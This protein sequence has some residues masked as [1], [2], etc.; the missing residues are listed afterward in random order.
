MNSNFNHNND[1]DPEIR[2]E[3]KYNEEEYEQEDQNYCDYQNKQSGN[4]IQNDGSN[5]ENNNT[6]SN[7]IDPIYVMSLE[8]GDKIE[9]IKIYPDSNPLDLA[10]NFCIKNNLDMSAV[11]YLKQQIEQ[12]II[13]YNNDEEEG[14]ENEEK[15]MV[16]NDDEN[17]DEILEEFDMGNNIENNMEKNM[18]NIKINENKNSNEKNNDGDNKNRKEIIS[19]IEKEENNGLKSNTIERDDNKIEMCDENNIENKKN[20]N[21]ESA[22][23]NN[24]KVRSSEKKKE[25]DE[26]NND[27][28]IY[29]NNQNDNIINNVLEK[30]VIYNKDLNNINLNKKNLNNNTPNQNEYSE[31]ELGNT[32]SDKRVSQKE[33]I[34][35]NSKKEPNIIEKPSFNDEK[36]LN[37]FINGKN[38]ESDIKTV[39]LQNKIKEK[40]NN[41]LN[42]NNLN[43]LNYFNN[44]TDLLDSDDGKEPNINE[45]N[46]TAEIKDVEGI[47]NN[48]ANYENQKPKYN[49]NNFNEN[50]I[51]IDK[52]FEKNNQRHNYPIFFNT[53]GKNENLNI[54]KDNLNNH[55]RHFMQSLE[56]NK[57]KIKGKK[58]N[59]NFNQVNIQS[60]NKKIS[61]KILLQ[62]N[63]KTP[64]L[65]Q[66]NI[67]LENK[68]KKINNISNRS[69]QYNKHNINENISEKLFKEAA[70][71][72]II[73]KKPCHFRENDMRFIKNLTYNNINNN[74]LYTN[75]ENKRKLSIKKLNLKLGNKISN[76]Y[77]EYLY[78]K[79][80]YYKEQKEKELSLLKQQKNDFEKKICTFKPN[81]GNNINQK[82]G[83]DKKCHSFIQN[84][85]ISN[86]SRKNL[87]TENNKKLGNKISSKINKNNN[88]FICKTMSFSNNTKKEILTTSKTHKEIRRSLGKM[89]NKQNKS[90]KP[91]SNKNNNFLVCNNKSKDFLINNS[92]NKIF[93]NIFKDLDTDNDNLLLSSNININNI[94]KNIA[95]ILKPILNKIQNN[96]INQIITQETFLNL[97]SQLFINLSSIDKRTILYTYNKNTNSRNNK[98]KIMQNL[99]LKNSGSPKKNDNWNFQNLSVQ[100]NYLQNKDNLNKILPKSE[101][102]IGKNFD[103]NYK[104]GYNYN[105]YGNKN[106]NN[107]QK[108]VTNAIKN[109]YTNECFD[110]NQKTHKKT[111]NDYLY[112]IPQNKNNSNY[113]NC[114][115]CNR[116]DNNN[117]YE[118]NKY[119]KINGNINNNFNNNNYNK[120]GY[121]YNNYF[122]L[123]K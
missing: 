4:Y 101:I 67:K 117:N 16:I 45:E 10:K 21:I 109:G 108:E 17:S 3:K 56:K 115:N 6:S 92:N 40:I 46:N 66:K 11:D 112:E 35:N 60:N 84:R 96:N 98:Y 7:E 8:L 103:L 87:T 36:K 80:K 19:N 88:D 29:E 89:E 42:S 39:I 51:K 119:S 86:N 15:N 59:R 63:I 95:K 33:I 31:K 23:E 111:I 81:I 27:N 62:K 22:N 30:N 14:D 52:N 102:K 24:L 110:T 122:I 58:S 20:Q 73:P 53:K 113:Y 97:M 34:Q 43:N 116:N 120:N 26:S 93:L 82:S 100:N 85:I 70:Y 55:N 49:F 47:N 57:E 12:L 50:E 13:E 18:E 5:Q 99:Y 105:N 94:P 64:I 104:Y 37:F 78:E 79:E 71:N 107:K 77:G 106:E 41:E 90:T 68:T 121:C 2:Y 83:K 123:N 61:P 38:E 72:R 54:K 48:K 76:N 44:K 75:N 25:N 28:N 65:K 9:K 74:M 118:K 91:Y 32:P 1:P 69:S 114:F